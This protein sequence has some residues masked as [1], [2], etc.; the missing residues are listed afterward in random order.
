MKLDNYILIPLI[1][2]AI[3][4]V[5][6]IGIALTSQSEVT[7]ETLNISGSAMMEVPSTDDVTWTVN[8]NGIKTYQ[9]PSKK[10]FMNAYNSAEDL[11]MEGSDGFSL[12]HNTLF[13]GAEDVES[14]HG[15]NIKE[16][17]INGTDYYIVSIGNETTHDNII[18]GSEDLDIL[19]HMVD[20]L[21]FTAPVETEDYDDAVED[22]SSNYTTYDDSDYSNDYSSSSS[23]SSSSSSSSSSGSSS[24]GSSSGSGSSQQSSSSSSSGSGSSSHGGS[25]SGSGSSSSGGG[26]SSGSGGS[27]G[28]DFVSG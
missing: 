24:S 21:V 20:S 16:N 14:Y 25:S 1:I 4:L 23:Q 10:V 6:G 13:D 7:Y 26:H 22:T 3:A 8:E 15:Y 2:I 18:V 11:S 5:V 28:I 17:H 9:C 27:G 12:M 19:K